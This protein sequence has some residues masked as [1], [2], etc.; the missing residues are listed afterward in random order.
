MRTRKK[1]LFTILLILVLI[2]AAAVLVVQIPSVQTKI[3]QKVTSKISGNIDGNISIEKVYFAIPDRLIVQGAKLTDDKG[4]TIFESKK[5]SVAVE[6][7]PLIK[8]NELIITRAGLSKG[9]FNFITE[10]DGSTNISKAFSGFGQKPIEPEAVQNLESEQNQGSE[11]KQKNEKDSTSS[12]SIHLKRFYLEDFSFSMV[13]KKTEKDSSERREGSK[14][15]DYDDIHISEINLDAKNIN[16]DSEGISAELERLSARESK[17]FHL[18]NLSGYITVKNGKINIDNLNLKDDFS[19]IRANYLSFGMD[20]PDAFSDFLN[21]VSL[22]VDFTD[23]VLDFRTLHFFSS[24]IDF[25]TLCL[26]LNGE[27]TGPVANLRSEYLSAETETGKTKIALS[28]HISGLPDILETM[29]GISIKECNTT[30]GDIEHIINQVTSSP[31]KPG[32]VGNILPSEKVSFTGS[33]DGFFTD[34][35]AFGKLETVESGV[36]DIDAIM[37]SDEETSDYEIIGNFSGKEIALGAITHSDKIGDLTFDGSIFGTAGENT[38]LELESLTIRELLFNNYNYQN[39]VASGFLDN[40]K[41]DGQIISDDPNLNFNFHGTVGF[42]QKDEDALYNF[43]LNLYNADLHALNFDERDIARV[44]LRAEADFFR[45]VEKDFFGELRIKDFQTELQEGKSDIGDIVISSLWAKSDYRLGINSSFLNA[46]FNGSATPTKFATDIIEILAKRELSN[47]FEGDNS[48]STI[49]DKYSIKLESADLRPICNFILPELYVSEGTSII[50]EINGNSADISLKS[51]LIAF[52]DNYIKGLEINALNNNQYTNAIVN[53]ATLQAG[54][55]ISNGNNITIK[56]DDNIADLR[57]NLMS[58]TDTLNHIEIHNEVTFLNK[59]ESADLFLS[60]FMTSDVMFNGQRWTIK[61][62]EIKFRNG[63][64]AIDDFALENALQNLK[65]NG[66]VSASPQERI[67]IDMNRFDLSILNPFL[68]ESMALG[69]EISG[70]GMMSAVLG[71]N[72]DIA[73]NLNG[74]EL[75]FAGSELGSILLDCSWDEAS[76]A[77]KYSFENKLKEERPVQLTGNFKPEDKNIYL[78]ARINRFDVSPFSNLA[79]GIVSNLSGDISTT[80]RV[81]GPLDNLKI[82]SR[83]NRIRDLGFVLDFTQVPYILNGTFSLT[84]DGFNLN[85]AE[86]RDTFGHKGTARG[87]VAMEKLKN[88]QLTL[89]LDLDNM[90]GLNTTSAD[91]SS[92]Y[93]KAFATGNVSM[94][95]PFSDLKLDIDI[96][97][98]QNSAIHIPLGSAA[99]SKT[100]MLTFTNNLQSIETVY[101]SLVLHN[102]NLN[103]S[104][105]S[106]AVHVRVDATPDAEIQIVINEGVGDAIK[107][108]GNGLVDINVG[109]DLFDIKGDYNITEGSY[110]LVVLGLVSR[111]FNIMQGGTIN[112]N[113]DIMQSDLNLTANYRTKASLSTL[114][115]DMTTR[116]NI[117]C[118]IGISGKLA[119]PELTFDIEVPD[120]DPTSQSIVESTM[121]T[122]EKQL[123]QMLTLLVTGGFMPDEQSGIVNNTT[124]LFSNASEI[125]SNQLNNVFRQFDI[126]LDLGF[127]YQPGENG[128]DIFD[129]AV[130]T[131]LFNNRVTING[132]IGNSQY[133]GASKSDIVGDVDME[134]KLTSSGKLRLTL[135]SHSADQY[136]AYLDQTQRNGAGIAYQEEFDTFKELWQ[137]IIRKKKPE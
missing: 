81:E 125:M 77:F 84:E 62:S 1:I 8:R 75:S 21:K 69:G 39:I 65:I 58:D 106:L 108:R 17:G 27:V 120:L 79:T 64:I 25:L 96:A 94:T 31:L 111:D 48:N 38:S 60:R 9:E 114:I 124:V 89:Q 2:P 10:A 13:N 67:N 115:P 130:S 73:L 100:S 5:I 14:A 92:F 59:D 28:T 113:G 78:N 87:G 22:G 132:N 46:E 40:T 42:P 44:K 35:V 133:L 83:N 12:L 97:T 105:G 53:C 112:F 109:E 57:V 33:L 110:K 34:F 37:R 103:S 135:F 66:I 56:L 91:N 32:T 49:E 76:Q 41:F 136:S 121:N 98:N 85:D 52:K 90:H 24:G 50:G 122:E 86:I 68:S 72:R 6:L 43:V 116:R 126:P 119:N 80:V 123:K 54:S 30:T 20:Q 11:A 82:T 93:G 15:M 74:Q 117:D 47:L 129:V 101:D 88:P 118:N 18:Q 95:G 102:A 36:V 63:H 16:Y 23:A 99:S 4:E 128:R 26:K 70:S 45:N 107:A 127:N 137:K 19:D 134:I 7:M 131:Q 29:V 51:D 71:E 61:P 3:C 55:I 104:S